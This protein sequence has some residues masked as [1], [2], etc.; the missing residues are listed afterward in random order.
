MTSPLTLTVRVLGPSAAD[1]N[2]RTDTAMPINLSD[3]QWR[4]LPPSKSM[5]SSRKVLEYRPRGQTKHP[6]L[7]GATPAPITTITE[8]G[9]L[10]P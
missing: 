5:Q 2:T 7:A 4:S 10:S 6:P 9:P 3:L 1:S 8:P